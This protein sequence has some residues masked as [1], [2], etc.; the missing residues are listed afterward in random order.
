VAAKADLASQLR[1][2]IR[3]ELT[4]TTREKTGE[5]AVQEVEDRLAERVNELLQD[6]EIVSRSVD[7]AKKLCTSVAVM[8]RSRFA[9]NSPRPAASTP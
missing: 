7:E 1:V 3:S 6:V 5:K 4:Q 9:L 2:E 8:P